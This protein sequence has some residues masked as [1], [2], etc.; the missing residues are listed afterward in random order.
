MTEP[1]AHAAGDRSAAVGGSNDGV[2]ITGDGNVVSVLGDLRVAVRPPTSVAEARGLLFGSGRHPAIGS[3][4]LMRW[5]A[6]DAGLVPVQPRRDVDELARWVGAPGEPLMRLV[7]GAG[8][9]GKTVLGRL[10]CERAAGQGWLAG[11]VRLPPPGWRS[12]D[13]GGAAS[14]HLRPWLLR[15]TE[16]IAAALALPALAAGTPGALL[17]V[18][19]A[20]NQAD[21]LADLLA[22]VVNPPAGED[23]TGH[24]RV[25]LLARHDRDW[26]PRLARD[27]PDRAW[28]DPEPVRLGPLPDELPDAAVREVWR[29]A[30][31]AFA[32]HAAETGAVPAGAGDRVAAALPP[33]PAATT[34]DLYAA[35]LLGVLDQA[36]GPHAHA[37]QGDPLEGV[38]EHER[39]L[40]TA[41]LAAAGLRLD[42]ATRDAALAAVFL[43][44]ARSQAEGAAALARLPALAASGAD[45][46]KL[47]VELG[48]LY[49]DEAGGGLWRA[50]APDRLPDTHLLSTLQGAPSD[51]DAVELIC[52]ATEG[53]TADDEADVLATLTRAATTPRA[54]RRYPAGL[55]RLRTATGRLVTGRA[56]GYLTAAIL[57]DP[58]AHE[59]AIFA[60]LESLSWAETD[61]VDGVLRRSGF[62]TTRTRV[63]VAVSE[64]LRQ[65]WRDN[66]PDGDDGWSRY[67]ADILIHGNR[68]GEDGRRDDALGPT[69]EAVTVY[70]RLAEVNPA[71]YLPALAG[72]LNNVSV[73]LG[74]LGRGEEGLAAVEEAVV[75]RR[76]LAEVNPAAYLPDLAG[77][78]NNVSVR[79]G[80]LGRGEEGLAAVEEAV[81]VYRR[82]AEVNPA[83]YLPD[84]ANSLWAVGWVC[85]GQRSQLARGLAAVEEAV[86]ILTPLAARLPAAH[87]GS[88]AA[89]RATM[90]DLLDQLGRTDDAE[91]VRQR[92]GVVGDSA[93]PR[94]GR[95][96]KPW[97]RRAGWTRRR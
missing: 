18:D 61:A 46:G 29:E 55:R 93:P 24:V 43:V 10:A 32:R 67:A 77:S 23:L 19:Y 16:V 75:I 21:V 87:D 50:P 65:F 71:A 84:L 96:P 35:A 47:A 6:P 58:R 34:L 72:S 28:V 14:S 57:L 49:P 73:D 69:T 45:L 92:G 59:G 17:V 60:A 89:M 30:V 83:A 52:T 56:G 85:V 38:L 36:A 41:C 70:R 25:L 31:A 20:E 7:T 94:G 91:Q 66:P 15:W 22:Q 51:A 62:A 11:F 3:R 88:L 37:V 53:A 40:V 86:A 78:L 95:R 42:D 5:L 90:A 9:Q 4:S 82:L 2:I 8:G 26:W 54:G 79:L 1:G 76:R 74:A 63:A 68:L 27:H 12:L 80:A 13:P 97:W 33:P 81:A 64:R 48:R 39:K 44:P